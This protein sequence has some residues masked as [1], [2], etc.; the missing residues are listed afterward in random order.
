MLGLGGCSGSGSGGSG[1]SGGSS[2][3]GSGF[4]SLPNVTLIIH[5][6]NTIDNHTMI[7]FMFNSH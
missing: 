1:G 3:S 2:G 4:G 6:N 7:S 5:T